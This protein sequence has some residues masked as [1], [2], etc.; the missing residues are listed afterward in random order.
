M[1]APTLL[2]VGRE[3]QKQRFIARALTGEDV[4]CQG[5][6]EPGAAAIS[7]RWRRAPSWSETSG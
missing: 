5:Y 6:S 2:D 3:D 7:R 1:L 4:W